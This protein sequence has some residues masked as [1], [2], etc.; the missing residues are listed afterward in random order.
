MEDAIPQTLNYMLAGYA[1]LLGLPLLY[2]AGWFWRRHQYQQ[3]LTLL[4]NLAAEAG[5]EPTGS[6]D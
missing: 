3:T 1:V 6:A 4:R 5:T 2:V